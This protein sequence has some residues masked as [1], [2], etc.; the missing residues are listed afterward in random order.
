M[1]AAGNTYVTEAPSS[2][3]FKIT[4]DGVI[5]QIIDAAG[6]GAGHVS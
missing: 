1:D 2:N 5:T 6:D 3:A 4:P